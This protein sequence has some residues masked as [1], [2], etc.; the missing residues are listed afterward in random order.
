M[1]VMINGD[2]LKKYR[3]EKK[4]TQSQ[5]A[6]KC[7]VTKQTIS[8]MEIIGIS[9]TDKDVLLLLANCLGCSP[10]CLQGFQSPDVINKIKQVKKLYLKIDKLSNKKISVLTDIANR[11]L[12]YNEYET[13]L[14]LGNAKLISSMRKGDNN[15]KE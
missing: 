13:N 3:K 14:L 4:M 10:E 11:M 7:H 8:R 9:K 2:I 6:S 15:E 5:V 12:K 1:T